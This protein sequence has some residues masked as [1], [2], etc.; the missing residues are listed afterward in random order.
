MGDNPVEDLKRRLAR[1]EKVIL[2]GKDDSFFLAWG[3]T[4][5][6]LAEKKLVLYLLV[7]TVVGEAGAIAYL[8]WKDQHRRNL[9]IA[10]DNST[11]SAIPVDP[12]QFFQT[13]SGDVRSPNELKGF[14]IEWVREAY[15]FSFLNTADKWKRALR[16]VD[17][18]AQGSAKFAMRAK[19][20]ADLTNAGRDVKIIE[21]LD[22]GKP[23]EA[24][25]DGMDPI[26]LT[27]AIR[28]VEVET[29]GDM[30]PL[31][32]LLVRMELKQVPRSPQN[33]HGLL[34]TD[35]SSAAS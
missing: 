18:G 30:K 6:W 16:F 5:A 15:S 17:S 3:R 13:T 23:L 4:M 20:R 12:E 22:H 25:L 14:A 10:V 1:I 29:N 8:G 32:S 28:R 27:V 2:L 19:E 31:P 34:I 21:D 35:V 33:P 24:L 26:R 11:G 7:F 9:V